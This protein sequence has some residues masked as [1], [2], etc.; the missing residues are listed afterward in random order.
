MTLTELK[1]IVA[2]ARE[3]HFG[4]A[5]EASTFLDDPLLGGAWIDLWR[6]VLDVQR[7]G[8]DRVPDRFRAI[9]APWTELAPGLRAWIGLELA[10]GLAMAN[11]PSM[12]R[13]ALVMAVGEKP[14]GIWR[15]RAVLV[16]RH[17][18]L[19]GCKINFRRHFL[20]VD[21]GV[22]DGRTIDADKFQLDRVPGS[23]PRRKR[24]PKRFVDR[25]A[26]VAT[27]TLK[28]AFGKSLDD[29]LISGPGASEERR[30]VKFRIRVLQRDGCGA[31]R[32]ASAAC[33]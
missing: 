11:D 5:A 19:I 9:T 17:A 31:R 24:A 25:R 15:D 7:A 6:A 32:C 10:R 1:Y 30:F 28:I 12:A 14:M 16:A 27:D 8:Y 21:R 18:H 13:A 4:R 23:F 29:H 33:P 2:V 20:A 22:A 26:H 3:K